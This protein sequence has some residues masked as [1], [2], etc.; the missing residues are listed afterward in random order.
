MKLSRRQ[1]ALFIAAAALSALPLVAKETVVLGI[2]DDTAKE[3]GPVVQYLNTSPAIEVQLKVFPNHDELYNAL[4][5]KK[6]DLA[7]LGAVK[8]VEAHFDFGATPIV[9]EGPTIRS[10]IV[11]APKS[12]IKTVAELKGKRFAFGYEDS[13]TTHLIPALLLS[14]HG[15]KE[16]DIK[17]SYVG[18]VPQKLIDALLAGKFDAAA[19]SDLTYDQNK[20]KVRA[21]EESDPFPGPPI[22]A[23]PGLPE[24]AVSEVRKMFV[25]YKPAPGNASMRFGKGATAVTDADYNRIRFLCKVLFNMMYQ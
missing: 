12:P 23:R 25:S 5:E 2:A 21:L 22:V 24:S 8:Y 19:A 9:S 14:K 3:I 18:H 16:K 17:G 15:I 1:L 6:V 11:V 10:Y 4:K 13:T 7:F 20:S